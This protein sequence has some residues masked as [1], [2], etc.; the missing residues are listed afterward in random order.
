MR[1]I[2]E[3]KLIYVSYP[4]EVTDTEIN[5]MIREGVDIDALTYQ[6]VQ[7]ALAKEEC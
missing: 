3:L 1:S 4:E 6:A 5:Y 7:S 2:D